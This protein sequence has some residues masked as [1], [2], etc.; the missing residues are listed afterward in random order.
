MLSLSILHLL[1]NL[2]INIL[3]LFKSIKEFTFVIKLK[4]LTIQKFMIY[5]FYVLIY[6]AINKNLFHQIHINILITMFYWKLLLLINKK[7]MKL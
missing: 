4:Y 6:L 5:N 7:K 1:N 2:F 3:Y